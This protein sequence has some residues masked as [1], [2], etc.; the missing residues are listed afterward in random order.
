MTRD[1]VR[2]VVID[3]DDSRRRHARDSITATPTHVRTG[4]AMVCEFICSTLVHISI[5]HYCI[6]SVLRYLQTLYTTININLNH[7]DPY[8]HGATVA[9]TNPP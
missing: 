4:T 2:V 7:I 3:N 9:F 6:Q 1:C 5:I 8:L